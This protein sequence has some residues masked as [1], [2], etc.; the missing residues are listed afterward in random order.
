[1]KGK[2]MTYTILHPVP[3]CNAHFLG[4]RFVDG[5]AT[6]DPAN[7][8]HVEAHPGKSVE[9]ILA[10]FRANGCE[11]AEESKAKGKKIAD[12]ETTSDPDEE[13]KEGPHALQS[14][15]PSQG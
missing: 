15:R 4:L 7:S 5:Q 1:L 9:E 10:T 11:I 3:K 12:V 8:T 2:T 13:K 14:N 6:F